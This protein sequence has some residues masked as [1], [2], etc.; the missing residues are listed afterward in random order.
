MYLHFAHITGSMIQ[1]TWPPVI[2]KFQTSPQASDPG[3]INKYLGIHG[4][5]ILH[6]A[7]DTTP[8]NH[9]LL[10]GVVGLEGACLLYLAG[11]CLSWGVRHSRH[12]LQEALLVKVPSSRAPLIGPRV[13]SL[14]TVQTLSS[15]RAE[16]GLS[17]ALGTQELKSGAPPFPVPDHPITYHPPP[18]RMWD[19]ENLLP[20]ATLAPIRE[21]SRRPSDSPFLTGE[22][23]S[24][25]DTLLRVLAPAAVHHHH[26]AGPLSPGTLQAHGLDRQRCSYWPALPDGHP[27][28]SPIQDQRLLFLPFPREFRNLDENSYVS[29]ISPA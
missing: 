24:Q 4:I 26:V 12:L 11:S 20:E 22:V 2:G 28:P 9:I 21:R 14:S 10:H 29:F 18:P 25:Q 15:L 27:F 3:P 7:L 13:K 17:T 6:K 16:T 1:L 23:D 19:P 5:L 8:I